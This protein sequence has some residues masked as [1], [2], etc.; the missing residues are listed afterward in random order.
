MCVSCRR[1][2]DGLAVFS[3]NMWALGKRVP[4]K[5]GQ[6]CDAPVGGKY[7]GGRQHMHTCLQQWRIQCCMFVCGAA[8][9]DTIFVVGEALVLVTFVEALSETLQFENLRAGKCFQAVRTGKPGTQ[10]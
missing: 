10:V 7:V 8:C 2:T 4:G 5:R 9:M 1:D 3:Q 6:Q